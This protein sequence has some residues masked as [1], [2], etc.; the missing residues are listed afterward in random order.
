MYLCNI[1]YENVKS[2]WAEW[3][4]SNYPPEEDCNCSS[5]EVPDTTTSILHSDLSNRSVVSGALTT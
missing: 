4:F 3:I 5:L 1:Q 2:Q